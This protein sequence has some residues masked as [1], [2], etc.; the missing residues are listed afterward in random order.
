V[1]MM[2]ERRSR[3]AEFFL[4]A[5]D[6]QA[7]VA[8]ANERAID[9]KPGRITE[10]LKLFCCFF[11]FHGNSFIPSSQL[12]S[13]DISKIVEIRPRSTPL[14]E[15]DFVGAAVRRSRRIGAPA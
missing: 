10:S 2:G 6:R 8:G 14:Q 13:I 7:V 5:A 9:L 4:Q 15:A 3:D 11:E 12:M 1:K